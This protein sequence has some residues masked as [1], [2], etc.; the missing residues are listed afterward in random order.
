MSNRDVSLDAYVSDEGDTT[1]MDY[2]TYDGEN[3]EM[4]LIKKEEMEIG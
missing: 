2:L 3:Q 1:H 4:S